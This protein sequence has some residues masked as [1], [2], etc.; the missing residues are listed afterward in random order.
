MNNVFQKGGILLVKTDM[1]G[2]HGF[3]SIAEASVDAIITDFPYG[4]LN[5]RNG[6]DKVI[7]FDKF[8]PCAKSVMK[9]TAPVI[10]TAQMP[11][12]AYLV[13]TNFAD[14][15][16]TMVWEK[17]KATGYLNAKKQPMRAH[18]DIVVF[19]KKQCKYNPQMTAGDPYDKG[20]AVRDT[21]AY[22]KQEKAVLVKNTTG[23]RYPRSIQYFVTAESEGKLHPT[24]KP[25]ALMEYLIRTYTNEGD[26]VM[27]P[28]CGSG[29]TAIACIR[30]GRKFIGFEKDAEYF[31]VA[32]E[33]IEKELGV[34]Q[35]SFADKIKVG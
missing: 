6:W 30:T 18:E 15:K 12:T 19:Y 13:S 11:F 23:L 29:T 26:V 24:Q 4:T 28:C 32:K 20:T 8:W 33:R 10:S 3:Q 35:L 5:K 21:L 2:Q 34:E 17:S 1:F 14:F 7:D 9:E 16:Y 25:V 27:D 31:K 22:G